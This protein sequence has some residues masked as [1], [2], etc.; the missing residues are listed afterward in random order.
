MLGAAEPPPMKAGK[1][2]APNSGGR[3]G[4]GGERGGKRGGRVY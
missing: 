2:P 3:R 4:R 1:Q